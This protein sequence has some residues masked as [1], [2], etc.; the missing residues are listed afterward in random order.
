MSNKILLYILLVLVL[1]LVTWEV[2]KSYTHDGMAYVDI[3][4]LVSE[5]KFK[6]DLENETSGNLYKIKNS[7]DSLELVRKT[8]TVTQ[9]VRIDSQIA[10]AKYA[11]DE[12]YT[13]SAED[14]NKK[15]WDRLNP[16]LEEYGKA[17][18]LELL[19]GADGAGT[20]LYAD[21]GRDMTDDLIQF[22]NKRYEG[23][24]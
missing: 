17:R 11:F 5:Y 2:K 21:K 6:K 22:V 3:A 8:M 1:G 18:G 4:K 9:P 10:Y 24:N 14:I 19:I 7:I 15:I 23:G 16:L 12:Y 20:L 13:K